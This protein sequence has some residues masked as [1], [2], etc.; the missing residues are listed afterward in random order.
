MR[1]IRPWVA[2]TASGFGIWAT[3]FIAML[4]YSPGVPSGYNIALTLLSPVAAVS[5]TGAGLTVAESKAAPRRKGLWR[6]KSPGTSPAKPRADIRA[7]RALP[8]LQEA[9][10]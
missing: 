6:P 1:D 9:G 3:H 10:Q 4:A 5:L 2:A 7:R 8:S